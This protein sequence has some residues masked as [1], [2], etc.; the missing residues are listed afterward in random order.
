[1]PLLLQTLA[2]ELRETSF[3]AAELEKLKQQ[4]IA[5]IREQQANTRARAY[6][7]F[8]QLVFDPNN[9]FYQH[10]GE[11]L[12]ASVAALTV[13]DV[14]RFYD[15]R[16]GGRSLILSIAGAV[17]ASD[18]RA[19][20]QTAFGAFAGPESIEVDVNDPAQQETM[21]REVVL[22]K[23]KA[24]VDVLLGSAAPL[25]RDAADY[26]AALLANSAL[27]ESTLSSRLGL[28]VRDREGLTYGIGSRFR[29]PSLAAGPWYIAVSVNPQNVEQALNSA[30]KVLRDYVAHGIREDE[31][32]DEKSS[33]IGSFKVALST[34]AGLAEALWNA[35]FYRLGTDYVDRYPQLIEAV[36]RAEV[37]AAI[38][39]YFRPE[40]LTVVIAGDYETATV[41]T[42]AS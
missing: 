29:A 10:A 11:W 34:N 32:A 13:A 2:E 3:P 39:K 31:L 42:P 24:N 33:A 23:D 16:Y 27:G 21:Q 30:L 37:N 18:V 26:Y 14:R 8:T 9:P 7:R 20:F 1:M 22:L 25:R 19:Q 17:N 4:T 15:E 41:G 12:I 6:E 35:E 38:R 36:T 40:Q 28:Q 5:A